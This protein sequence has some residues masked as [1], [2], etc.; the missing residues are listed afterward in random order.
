MGI[1]YTTVATLLNSKGKHTVN[2]EFTDTVETL[3]PDSSTQVQQELDRISRSPVFAQS[4]RLLA[5][6]RFVCKEL[7]SARAHRL[8]QYTIAVEA[9]GKDASFDPGTDPL[10]RVEARRLRMKLLEYYDSEGQNN[11][12]KLTLP[13]GQYAPLVENRSSEIRITTFDNSNES[14]DSFLEMPSV[15]ILPFNS[16][17]ED[18][19]Q[20]FFA[21]GITVD[22]IT[23]LAAFRCVPVIGRHSSFAYRDTG[24]DL[25]SVANEL[26]ARYI[27]EGSVRRIQDRIRINAELIDARLNRHLWAKQFDG[28]D[29]DIFAV[30]DEIVEK[31]VTHLVPALRR[32]ELELSIRRQPTNFS[33]WLELN[34]G[35][36]YL[37]QRDEENIKQAQACFKRTVALDPLRAQGFTWLSVCEMFYIIRGW[38]KSPEAALKNAFDLASKGIALD[39]SDSDTHRQ[40]SV[41]LTY[42]RRHREAIDEA[43][44]SIDLNPSSCEAHYAL[45]LATCFVGDLKTSLSACMDCLKLNPTGLYTA[46]IYSTASLVQLMAS[47]YDAAV[48]NA[49][50]AMRTGGNTPRVYHRLALALMNQGDLQGAIEAL[51]SAQYSMPGP[52]FEYFKVTYPFA[53]PKDFNFVLEGL[54]KCGWNES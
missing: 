36:W 47:E 25:K 50:M 31:I 19:N 16:L 44:Q 29:D 24:L 18:I 23:R 54:R 43:R 45:A 1:K 35:I 6:L 10:V 8:T 20:G 28:Q 2:S 33:Y 26:G 51:R 11:P 22:I 34:R 48:D 53:N 5:F 17:S 27:V 42:S 52:S 9:L 37:G 13:K 39:P 21:D 49:R 46:V 41:C 30:Q 38:S 7:I 3:T 4:D 12:I 14:T 32:A 15:A 40:L